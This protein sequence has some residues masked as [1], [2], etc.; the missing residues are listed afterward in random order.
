MK[1]KVEILSPAGDLER[2]KI[3]FLYGADAIYIGGKEYSLRANALNFSIDE[4]KEICDFAHKLHKKVY[5]TFNILF[6]NEDLNA[7]L[8]YLE[9]VSKTNVDALI[10][11]DP[12]LIPI[13]KKSYP[14]IDIFLSTQN[15]AANTE[16]V[17]FW[18]D[19][20]VKRIVLAREVSQ[21]EIKEIYDATKADLEVF[22]H[23]AMC[24]NFSGR[25]VL[26]NYFTNRD[27]NRGGCAQICRFTFDIEKNKE[28]FCI[29]PK[30]LNMAE[31]IPDL[32]ECGVKSL[33]IEGR[34]RSMYYLAT[35]ISSYR[36]L[37]DAYYNNAFTKELLDKES[38]VLQRVA[39]RESSSHFFKKKADEKDQYY[40]GR[41]EVSN[42]DFLGLVLD[43]D[44]DNK[45]LTLEQ[46]NY[47]KKGDNVTIFG[48]NN[49]EISFTIKEL[50]DE[51]MNGLDCARHPQQIIKIKC[52]KKVPTNSMMKINIFV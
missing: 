9:Q 26:S 38:Q 4:I 11:G 30:D 45:I 52:N 41:E 16:S 51:N 25:C 29:S 32:I 7:Y 49:F 34:M 42:Q 48:P 24:T 1:N 14:Q 19:E 44:K 15:G 8:D 46:R 33:K 47:F 13:I 2:A 50:Y 28:K 31:C 22:I 5:L 21:K 10:I 18:L 23:G 43:Y 35:V 12:F 37:V 3:A 36:K 20:G 17:E 6:H 40:I 27:A 39:N